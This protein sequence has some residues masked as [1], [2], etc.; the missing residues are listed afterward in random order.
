MFLLFKGV[1]NSR[2][3]FFYFSFFSLFFPFCLLNLHVFQFFSTILFCC[4]NFVLY[5]FAYDTSNILY[6]WSFLTPKL[7]SK[8]CFEGILPWAP[9][10]P[11]LLLYF[12]GFRVCVCMFFLC[13]FSVYAFR[14]CFFLIYVGHNL[15]AI[16][17]KNQLQVRFFSC[18]YGCNYCNWDFSV[19]NEVAIE[20]F[21]EL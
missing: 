14:A 10:D 16:Q 1:G 6:S 13:F 4:V 2:F 21:F 12:V 7:L 17:K 20:I 3:S 9:S 5:R 19:A 18:K 15:F 8:H 11:R